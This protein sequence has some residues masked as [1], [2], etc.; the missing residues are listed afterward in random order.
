MKAC[1]FLVCGVYWIWFTTLWSRRLWLRRSSS[2]RKIAGLTCSWF[3]VSSS[4]MLN[5]KFLLMSSISVWTG[6]CPLP[7]FIP[8]SSECLTRVACHECNHQKRVISYPEDVFSTPARCW[9]DVQRR[10]RMM[11]MINVFDDQ[12]TSLQGSKLKFLYVSNFY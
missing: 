6:E 9:K 7:I 1:V 5:P 8:P 4:K 10:A 11:M 3:E 12:V 2:N